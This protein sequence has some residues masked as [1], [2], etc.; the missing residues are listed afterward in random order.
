M[1]YRGKVTDNADPLK[2]D[3]VKVRISGIHPLD[4]AILPDGDLQWADPIM[5]VEASKVPPVGAIVYCDFLDQ[6]MQKPVY[7][8]QASYKKSDS[9]SSV[10]DLYS[11][12]SLPDA[13]S[14][15]DAVE[16]IA[17]NST[18]IIDGK[19][20]IFVGSNIQI[21]IDDNKI[22]F[23]SSVPFGDIVFGGLKMI[24]FLTKL[25]TTGNLG[26]PCPVVPAQIIQLVNAITA[27][28]DVSIGS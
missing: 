28:T 2:L 17:R 22:N 3:R 18:V 16:H 8:G 27:S 4:T 13:R 10:E 23:H 21:D 15:K 9:S 26:L 11:G 1:L 5:L 6:N 24:D 7:L 19:A 14:E 25:Q 12:K 20:R